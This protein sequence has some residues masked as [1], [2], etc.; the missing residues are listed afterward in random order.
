MDLKNK[1]DTIRMAGSSVG[2]MEGKVEAFLIFAASVLVVL[3][4]YNTVLK[5]YTPKTVRGWIGF[6]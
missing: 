5:S 6:N 4:F 1:L 3:I 2:G